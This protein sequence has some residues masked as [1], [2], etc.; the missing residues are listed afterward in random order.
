MRGSEPPA[1]LFDLDGT[2]TDPKEGIRRSIA[3]ALARVDRPPP[4]DERALDAFIGPPLIDSFRGVLGL[5]EQTAARAVTYYRE[6]FR[7]Q[8]LFENRVYPGIVETL[9][10]LKGRGFN[11]VVATSKPTEFARRILDHFGLRPFFRRT[12]GSR[13]DGRRVSKT[14]VIGRVLELYPSWSRDAVVMVGDRVHD[15]VGA[16]ENG[17]RSVAVLYGYGSEAELLAAHPTAIAPTVGDLLPTLR[18]L[19]DSQAIRQ[20]GHRG[21]G[22][23]NGPNI[24]K[25]GGQ[26]SVAPCGDD[27]RRTP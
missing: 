21:D 20:S 3:Y 14:A 18:Q 1:V 10:D 25:D 5:D 9:R 24:L 4:V 8:G 23:S 7:E 2:L 13:L 15:I 17:I 19:L 6:Y 26:R 12:V 27:A 16:A 11:L 22:P